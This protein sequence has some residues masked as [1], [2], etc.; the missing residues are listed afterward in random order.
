MPLPATASTNHP[1]ELSRPALALELPTQ[2][3][4]EIAARAAELL[5]PYLTA[6]QTCSP[7]MTVPEAAELLRCKRQR[8]DDLLSAR[9]LTRH[10]EGRRT[11]LLRAEVEALPEA[12]TGPR[13][14][15]RR[16]TG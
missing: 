5:L 8:I 10:K 13:A 7:Y 2:L 15:L 1:T 12:T 4:E 14:P 3:L 16:P 9:K 6:A 11:L